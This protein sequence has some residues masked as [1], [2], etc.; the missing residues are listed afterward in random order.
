MTKHRGSEM[1]VDENNISPLGREVAD[2]LG[3]VWR[4]L[5]HLN[6]NKVKWTDKYNISV[7]IAE[8][9]AT[10]DHA[11]LTA[12]VIL[13]HDRCIRLEIE[14]CNSRYIKLRFSQRK[15]IGDMNEKHPT[16]EESIIRV[17]DEIGLPIVPSIDQVVVH[18]RDKD[19]HT[20]KHCGNVGEGWQ[21]DD[22]ESWEKADGTIIEEVDESVGQVPFTF[23][24]CKLYKGE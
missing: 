2:I 1:F 20:C 6:V 24:N 3:Q 11:R 18:L 22:K 10:W 12:L 9:L 13:Y 14:P 19:S 7:N 16:I 21:A 23:I 5:Y 17:R 15:R 8:G 4:G